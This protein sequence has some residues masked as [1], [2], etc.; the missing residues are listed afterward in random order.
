[1]QFERYLSLPLWKKEDVFFIYFSFYNQTFTCS[2]LLLLWCSEIKIKNVC[3]Q[4]EWG[5]KKNREICTH[6]QG[7]ERTV[8]GKRCCCVCQVTAHVTQRSSRTACQRWTRHMKSCAPLRSPDGSVWRSRVPCGS[9]TGTWLMRRVGSV[10]RNS[11]CPLLTW[12]M[13][14]PASTCFSANTR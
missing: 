1:M 14:S 4:W 3:A 9:S 8:G 11:S 12:V 5:K 6:A 13:T 7:S 10:K 2:E